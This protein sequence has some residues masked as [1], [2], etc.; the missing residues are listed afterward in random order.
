MSA[1][2]R[3]NGVATLPTVIIL[4]VIILEVAI[5]AVVIAAGLANTANSQRISS[6]ALSDAK[7]GTD[8]AF[9][10]ILRYKDCPNITGCPASY[11]INIPG[12][13]DVANVTISNN[14]Q[15]VITVISEGVSSNRHRKLKMLVGVDNS[16]GL[17]NLQSMQEIPD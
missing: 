11:T 15:G 7:T 4:S 1:G 10:R 5:A 17:V 8:D 9:E 14:G 13:N 2:K 3:E 16:T 6:Q 12:T